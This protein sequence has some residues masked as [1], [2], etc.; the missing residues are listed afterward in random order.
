MASIRAIADDSATVDVVTVKVERTKKP[1]VA[2]TVQGPPA[3]YA[4]HAGLRQAS[5]QKSWQD[6]QRNPARNKGRRTMGRAGGR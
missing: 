2:V 4:G 5:R 6:A 3:R 1:A